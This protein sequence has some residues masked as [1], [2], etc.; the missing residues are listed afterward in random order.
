MLL[1]EFGHGRVPRAPGPVENQTEGEGR[2]VVLALPDRVG[3]LREPLRQPFPRGLLE[4]VGGMS[5][6]F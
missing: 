5:Y 4:L 3:E 6:L 2:L 1:Q